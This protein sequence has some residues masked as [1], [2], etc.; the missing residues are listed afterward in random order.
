MSDAKKTKTVHVKKFDGGR[1]TPDEYFRKTMYSGMEC[2]TCGG[3]PA[4]RARFLAPIDE[5]RA[6]YPR[7]LM[8]LVLM[9]GGKDPSFPTAY[10]RMVHVQSL[11]ACDQCKTS[12]QRLAA[13]KEDWFVVEFEE[14]GL[15]STH[16]L[17]VAV[18]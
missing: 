10:G 1:S 18:P 9:L 17:V 8:Q 16:K 12:L 5:F 3:P 6:K 11:F 4:M 13:K 2:S 15:S 7:E 14:M